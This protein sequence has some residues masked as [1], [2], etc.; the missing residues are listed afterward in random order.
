MDHI[1]KE[2]EVVQGI[3]TSIKK[4]GCF[5]SFDN[6][7]VGLLHISEISP[8]YISNVFNCFQIGDTIN[9]AV[10]KIDNDTK[11]LSVSIK[12]LP[13]SQAILNER[14]ES[15]KLTNYIKNIDFSKLDKV[16][17]LLIEEEL[18]REKEK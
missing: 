7:Y 17:P 12:D 18:K 11:Y 15:K 14:I 13:D 1:Y 6:G 2:N 3:V 5:L 4:Y 10:K 16:L 9:V 8:H